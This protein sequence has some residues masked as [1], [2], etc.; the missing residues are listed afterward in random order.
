MGRQEPDVAHT[1]AY[2]EG[3]KQSKQAAK[4]VNTANK[5]SGSASWLF[6]PVPKAGALWVQVMH[7][8]I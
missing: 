1:H 5:P 2:A 3:Q 4:S 6:H 8:L 7:H